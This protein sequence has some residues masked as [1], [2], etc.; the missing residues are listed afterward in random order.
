[1]LRLNLKD[2]SYEEA[3]VKLQDRL[4]IW[5]AEQHEEEVADWFSAWWCGPVKGVGCSATLGTD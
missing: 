5:L 4:C 2:C 3:G 1:M